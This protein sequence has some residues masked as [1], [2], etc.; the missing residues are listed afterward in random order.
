MKIELIKI[1][2][3]TCNNKNFLTDTKANYLKQ[4]NYLISR[5]GIK[6]K[7]KTFLMNRN[8]FDNLK[9]FKKFDI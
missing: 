1:Y 2:K 7:S 9:D 5:T 6:F 3:I 4:I 8:D